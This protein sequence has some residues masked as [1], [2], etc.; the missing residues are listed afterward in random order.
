M[1]QYLDDSY[2]QKTIET[3]VT[4]LLIAAQTAPKGRGVNT[5][6]IISITGEDKYNLANQMDV[7]GDMLSA[8]FFHRDAQNVRDAYAVVLIACNDAVRGLNCAYCGFESC[9]LKPSGVPCVFNVVDLGIA[10]GSA[11]SSAMQFKLDNRILYSA[12]RAAKD[13]NL[14]EKNMPIIFAIPLSISEKNIFFDR[15]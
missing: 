3:V 6:T 13:L 11:V 5:L 10:L 8:N 7:T 1:I 15:K 2:L 14:F 4:P 9:E 12:G